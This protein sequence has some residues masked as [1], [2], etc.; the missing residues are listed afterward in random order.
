[1][2]GRPKRDSLR[3]F[4]ELLGV[5]LASLTHEGHGHTILQLLKIHFQISTVQ[6]SLLQP[7]P[8]TQVSNDSSLKH[9]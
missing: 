2:I 9:S 7:Q 3:I 6:W 8:L 1:M 5:L 4:R